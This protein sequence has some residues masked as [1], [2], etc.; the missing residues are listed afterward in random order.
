[1][2]SQSERTPRPI[3]GAVECAT[4][5]SSATTGRRADRPAQ[6]GKGSG[7]GNSSRDRYSPPRN[8]VDS[9]ILTLRKTDIRNEVTP[10]S[11]SVLVDHGAGSQAAIS[12][13]TQ[14]QA[15]GGMVQEANAHGKAV[16]YA[17]VDHD[18][19]KVGM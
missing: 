10:A 9:A 16:G 4:E 13:G 18:S 17:D 15:A 6:N 5:P 19:R 14:A 12:G 7:A 1:M 8:P 3:S 11:L 2:G